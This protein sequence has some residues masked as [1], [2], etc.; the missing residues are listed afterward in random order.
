MATGLLAPSGPPRHR[1]P[2]GGR[3]WEASAH[4]VVDPGG[5]ADWLYSCGVQPTPEAAERRNRRGRR[6]VL[7]GTLATCCALELVTSIL[8]CNS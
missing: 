1:L 8:P 6:D 3:R 5:D 2:Q 4:F 7:D